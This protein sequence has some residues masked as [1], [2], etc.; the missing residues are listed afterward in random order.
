MPI[1]GQENIN[2]GAQNEAANS[3]SLFTAFNKAQ[4]NFTTLF[5][6]SSQYTNFVG[7][8][9]ITTDLNSNT[10]TVTINNT[11]VTKLTAGTGIAV[12]TA[13][14]NVVISVAGYSNGSLVAGVTNVGISSSTLQI[15]NSPIVS[16]GTIT[17]DLPILSNII[18]GTYSNPQLEVDSFGRITAVQN[19]FISGTVTSVELQNG[20]GISVSGGP[21]VSDGVITVT[22]TGVRKLNQGPGILL[23]DTT[24]EITISANLSTF[25]GTVSRVT[26]TSNTLSVSNPTITLAG[27]INIELPTNISVSGNI[28]GGGNFNVGQN[29]SVEGNITANG[30]LVLNGINANSN[31]VSNANILASGIISASGNILSNGNISVTSVT[32]LRVP[33]GTNGQI[34]QTDGTGN[35][36]WVT[37]VANVATLGA[38]G[39]NGQL[40]FNDAGAVGANAGLSFNKTT[41]VLTATSFS[42]TYTG[43]GN[44]LSNIQGANISG[45]VANATFANTANLAN[46]ANFVSN[47][48]QLS[49]TTL[50]N[51]SSLSVIGNIRGNS[52]IIANGYMYALTPEANTANTQVATTAYVN[53][54]VGNLN[55]SSNIYAPI[56]NPIFTGTPQAPT[57][58]INSPGSNA[59]A[60]TEYVKSI[61]NDSVSNNGE[62]AGTIKL[63]T[64]SGV[65]DTTWAFC[66]GQ[67][68]NR[69]NYAALFARI[70]TTYGAGDGINTFNLP[71]FR[72]KFAV[73]AGNL[74][75]R[76]STGGTKDAVVVEHTHSITQTPHTHQFGVTSFNL[77][78]QPNLTNM[79]RPA[80]V[81][82]KETSTGSNANITIDTTG[83][84]G[85]NQNLP[86]YLGTNYIIKLVDDAIIGYT[87]T[88]G[89]GVTLSTT[90]GVTVI[91]A[92][93]GD[94]GAQGPQGPVG[95][96]PTNR[97][98]RVY[99]GA[100]QNIA[101]STFTKLN[102]DTVS[103]DIDSEWDSPNKRFQPSTAGYYVINAVTGWNATASLGMTLILQI[104][105]NGI[106]VSQWSNLI[107]YNSGFNQTTAINDI[108]YLNGSTDYLELYVWQNQAVN[109]PILGTSSQTY[110]TAFMSGGDPNAGSNNE[111]GIGVG[112]TWQNVT[113]T[114]TQ[115]VTYTNQTSKPIQ[116]SIYCQVQGINQ[117][118]MTLTVGGVI[119]ATM[120]HNTAGYNL[121]SYQTLTA[122]V[123]TGTTYSVSGTGTISNWSELR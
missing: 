7:S 33:G 118:S 1:P 41:G 21:I 98:T 6:Q 32:R 68:V 107:Y 101:P 111:V 63:W 16:S 20:P 80:A 53:S 11:G 24:G 81:D 28:Q 93:K 62:K 31:I 26:V 19:S 43:S 103:F 121:G 112:Q 15:I 82:P 52:S 77:G 122:I 69:Q 113:S 115:G 95:L 116:V 49:I 104:R 73:G 3:D 13:N 94:T 40:L 51:L 78:S 83:V 4:N 100:T 45:A 55:L 75:N 44:N 90:N 84:S 86:P 30:N 114:R 119:V 87:L 29:L 67:A 38:V 109:F 12:S 65:P 102:I 106:V 47:S 64:G 17:V 57:P 34:L 88:Q 48:T 85:T 74:Y 117:A 72:D 79:I 99:L 108:I 70:G 35:L 110:F 27:N 36:S 54:I 91:S 22:N 71:D 23:T 14:G 46:V 37:P 56:N 92:V 61:I 76:G 50:G 18:P 58:P 42:G 66:N 39:A 8:E 105:K 96:S 120:G 89:N 5:S 123:P 60:T 2:I 10:K 25:S 59:L 97:G 9:G